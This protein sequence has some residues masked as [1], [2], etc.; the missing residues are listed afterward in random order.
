ML[1]RIEYN[2]RKGD[3]TNMSVN[4]SRSL[5]KYRNKFSGHNFEL[6]IGEEARFLQNININNKSEYERKS[7][8]C[9]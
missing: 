7:L 4:D 6:N 2:N 9:H 5:S 1:K 3:L 8:N